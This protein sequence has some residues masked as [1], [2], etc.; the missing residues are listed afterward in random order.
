[1]FDSIIIGGGAAGLATAVMIK[2]KLNSANIAVF[3]QLDR[4]GKKLSITGNGRCN[5][6]NL[7]LD[8]DFFHSQN[9][10]TPLKIISDFGLEN[11]KDFFSSIGVEF[12]SE[13]NKIYPRS[14]QAPSVV[15]ALRFS[16]EKLGVKLQVSTKVLS[17]KKNHELFIVSTNNG[18]FK[19]KSI[20]IAT[21]GLAGG[22][23]LGSNGDGYV[24][25]KKLGHN[26]L[27]Q[28]PTI[29]QLKTENTITKMLKGIKVNANATL[30]SNGEIL[31]KE[32]GEILFCDYG[33]S[34]PPILQISRLAKP[35]SIVSLDLFYDTDFEN[36]FE[37]LIKR[38]EIFAKLPLTEFFAGFL[39]K[40]LGQ[41][42]IKACNISLSREC[43]SLED[44]EIK[45]IASKL[46]NFKFSVT[47]NTGFANAQATSGGADLKDFSD[48]LMSK[49]CLGLFAVGEVLDVDGDCGGYNLH[50]AWS[51][52]NAVSQSVIEYLR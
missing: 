30:L 11:V 48:S 19:C 49:K 26:I 5:I 43:N 41:A 12:I 21:G 35:G 18:D 45:S 4:V 51:S 3:E 36:L 27:P 23:K 38:K 40:R 42:V 47:G 39:N 37:K 50:W 22:N 24:F 2:Q 8:C 6:S 10:E 44:F 20:I 1:M 33:L 14:L 15:D 34:G 29:V 25:L 7:N 32:F 46:K 52:A 17:V 9:N 28:T 16:A 13:N 31:K